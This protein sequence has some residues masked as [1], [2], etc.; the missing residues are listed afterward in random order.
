MA[1]D[2]DT[3]FEP[4][5]GRS[6]P[7]GGGRKPAS[8]LQRMTREVT[9]AG[10]DPRRISLAKGTSRTGRFNVRG[11]GRKA[12]ATFPRQSG[13][14]RPEGGMRFRARRLIVK[15][16]VV[17]LRGGKSKAAYA[18]LRYLQRDGVTLDGEGGRLYSANLDHEDGAVF[19]GRGQDDRHQFRL[20]VAPEDGT[21]LGD[22]RD[23][24]RQ[25]MEQMEHDL[26]TQLDWV[27]VDHHNTGHPHSHVVIRGMTDDGK[28]LNIAGDYIAHGI[29]HRA[30]EIATLELGP[31]SEWEVQQKLGREVVQ[32][33][34]TRLDRAILQEVNDQGLVDLRIGEEQSY[35]GRANRALLISRLKRLE[36]MGLAREEASAR[37]SLSG[38]LEKTL[39]ELGKRGDIIKTMHR[40]MAEQGLARDPHGYVIHRGADR[41]PP[42]VG[43]VVG[44]G[45]AGDELT[46]RLHLVIDGADGRVHYAE[47]TET[48][49]DGITVGSIVEVGRAEARSRPAD[50]N[51]AEQ[52]RDN[53]GLYGP[54][55][56]LVAAR[57]SM[58][59]PD[60]N[61]EGYVQAHVRRL[62]ALR[63]AGIVERLGDGNWRIP[64]DFEDR[65]RDY[66]TGRS[67]QLGVRMLSLIDLDAQVTANAA[68]WLDRELV[69]DTPT[70][71]RDGGFGREARDALARRRQWLI[72]QGLA[73]ETDAGFVTRR[74]MLANLTRREVEET[75]KK[76]A[77]PH[78][79]HFRMAESGERISGTYR[80]SVQLVSGKYA[81]VERSREFTLVPWRPVIEK[82]LGRQVTGLVRGSG[83]SWD[84][85]RKRGRGIGM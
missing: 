44:K 9:R 78:G 42:T 39:Q 83:I 51:I 70:P 40:V 68:T 13:W 57:D 54:I 38:R 20:I 29:R 50:R 45:L 72:A 52:A 47:V 74:D 75:G 69:A 56:H 66:D 36:R 65:A 76:L 33:R 34:F 3:G 64:K 46:G 55:M 7:R 8:F 62:E 22:L 6:R 43:K 16:R 15:A 37:W 58:R 10:G 24:T 17:K 11:R 84:L 2:D 14:S 32:D 63:R 59:L 4:R 73:D 12:V 48:A 18:H 28:I 41:Q 67:K 31:Q 1:R 25:L 60:G 82:A 35:L 49:G 77:G 81:L 5:L 80:Q 26:D 21:E 85:G 71:L 61:Y 19:L 79:L 30:S 53:G 23:F 27:A